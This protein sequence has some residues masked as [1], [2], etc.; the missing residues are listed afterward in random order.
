M[1]RARRAALALIVVTLTACDNV[2]WGGVDVAIVHP[3]PQGAGMAE[4]PSGAAL[5]PLPG[6]DILY[7][8]ARTRDGATM[9][10]VGEMAGD[11]LIPIDPGDDPAAFGARL[12]AE[13]LRQGT[14]FALFR[15]GARVGT[16]VL[17]GAE[18]TG[19][20]ACA[21]PTAHGA[22]ELTGG[23]DGLGEFLAITRSQAP[24]MPRRVPEVME[25][26]GTMSRLATYAAES[27]LR[28]RGSQLP[29]NWQRAMAQLAPFPTNGS[30]PGF[31][32]TLLVSDTLGPGLD[33]QGYSLFF[34]GVP[35]QQMG[36][37]TVFAEYN[38]YPETGKRAPRVLDYLD[39]DR[40]G[41]V[42]LL[43]RVYGVDDAWFEAV[44][45]TDDGAWRR[46]FRDRCE[47]PAG[48]LPTVAPDSLT[49]DTLQGSRPT[50]GGETGPVGVPVTG[51]G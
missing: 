41:H 48:L 20:G 51:G 8:V 16:F 29:G 6:G 45:R 36:Y 49:A 14:E 31:A 1:E 3:P 32:A 4:D 35:A 10:P 43:L 30:G 27:L 11:T 50:G 47:R 26:T 28:A 34:V 42:E 40:D 12:V 21:L 37:D 44:G 23:A 5:T 7:F 33:D 38:S 2:S 15:H 18:V 19:T 13:R 25:P 9:V 24:Q 22:L 46:I 39:W 17:G